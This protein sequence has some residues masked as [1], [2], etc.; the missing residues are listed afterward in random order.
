MSGMG[1]GDRLQWVLD[2][3]ALTCNL[4]ESAMTNSIKNLY[5]IL[6]SL[7][8]VRLIHGSLADIRHE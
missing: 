7:H 3:L 4:K 6:W 8:F 1:A 5:L 2:L